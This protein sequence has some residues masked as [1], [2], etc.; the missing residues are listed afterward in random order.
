MR[1]IITTAAYAALAM[2]AIDASQGLP[3]PAEPIPGGEHEPV[4]V[5]HYTWTTADPNDADRV[6]VVCDPT[7]DAMIPELIA[8]GAL[9]PGVTC[10]EIPWSQ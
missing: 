10:E 6:A 2:Q 8:E 5:M 9:P 7:V 1:G 4:E 3:A